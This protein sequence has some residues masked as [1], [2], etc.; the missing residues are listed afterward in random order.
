MKKSSAMILIAA[1]ISLAGPQFSQGQG[2]SSGAKDVFEIDN[3]GVV[4]QFVKDMNLDTSRGSNLSVTD[5]IKSETYNA[6]GNAYQII[7]QTQS[8]G[9]SDQ[10]PVRFRVYRCQQ[11]R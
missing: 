1:L 9:R 2:L 5:Q 6:G 11:Q 3:A 8:S 4:C 7:P 10:A